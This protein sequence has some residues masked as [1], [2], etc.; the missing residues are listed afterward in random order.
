M[1]YTYAERKRGNAAPKKDAAPAQPSLEALRSGSAAPTAEQKGHRVDL[2]EAMREKMETAFGADL[3]AVKL[4]ESEAVGE[5]GA[6]AI[7]QGSE[8]AFAPGM[9][10]FT[11]FEGQALLGHEISHV[12]SQARGEVTGGGFLNDHA[13]EAR[14]DAEGAM[15]A[16]GQQVSAPMS[17][18]S[19]APAAGPMQADKA[20]RKS[21]KKIDKLLRVSSGMQ[22]DETGDLVSQK[23]RD[24][25]HQTT[26]SLSDKELDMIFGRQLNAAKSMNRSYQD[27]ANGATEGERKMNVAMS[28]DSMDMTLYQQIIRDFG[29]GDPTSFVDTGN[30]DRMMAAAQRFHSGLSDEDRTQFEAAGELGNGASTANPYMSTPG[31]EDRANELF[32]QR[33]EGMRR[34]YRT[35]KR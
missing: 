7:T 33:K 15:A 17:A 8:I 4:Y 10:D 19:A 14:A 23:D 12:V 22:T 29:M 18:V 13:L 5:A 20:E 16:A 1:S 26:A 9:L 30:G 24:W 34:F 2:P 35:G 6:N 11:S 25:Y 28:Q 3:S 32:R 31:A 27:T 21:N